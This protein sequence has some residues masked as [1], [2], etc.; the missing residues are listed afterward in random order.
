MKRRA[1]LGVVGGAAAAWPLAARAQQKATLVGALLSV[2]PDGYAERMRAFRHG[3]QESGYIEGQNV[4]IE[5]RWAEGHI[6]RLPALAADL[7]LH[8]VAVIAALGGP[9]PA[10]AAKA[11]TT[12]IPVVFGTPD[13]PVKLGLVR[14]LARPGGNLTGVYYFTGE[15]VAKR[16]ELLRRLVPKT[17]RIAMFVNLA[18]SAR[19]APIVREAETVG[20]A[21]GLHIQIFEIRNSSEIT[22]AFNMFADQR[23]DAM[24]VAPDPFFQG[25]RVQIVELA[26]R[27]AIPVSY[28]VRDFCDVGG[29]MSY[30]ADINDGFRQVGIYTGRVLKGE[31]PADLPVVQATKIEFVIN[32]KTAKSLGLEIHPQLLATADQV[33]E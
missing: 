5:Y 22:A 10:V 14:S 17:T 31:K 8:K 20:R 30:G 32:L 7:V 2:S 25:H 28:S 12:T 11:T 33:I 24:F 29:L 19:M 4:A 13:D 18:N 6:D 16:L 15:L 3:L 21:M 9:F 1:F 27:H 23:P 26:A